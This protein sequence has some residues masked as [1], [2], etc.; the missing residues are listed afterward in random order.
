MVVSM[1]KFVQEEIEK[2]LSRKY[3]LQKSKENDEQ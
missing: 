2:E 3:L 1:S